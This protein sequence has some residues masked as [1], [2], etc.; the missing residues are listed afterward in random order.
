M[1][2]KRICKECKV[3]TIRTHYGAKHFDPD[4]PNDKAYMLQKVSYT[5]NNCD[6]KYSY[7]QYPNLLA[8]VFSN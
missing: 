4:Y 2:K 8:D 3:G 6:Y 1:K 5:C 7:K